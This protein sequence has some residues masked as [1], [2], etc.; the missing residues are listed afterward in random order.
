MILHLEINWII[1]RIL[2]TL[3]ET[4]VFSKVKKCI[5]YEIVQKVENLRKFFGKV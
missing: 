3:T 2:L 1:F 5:F 4:P